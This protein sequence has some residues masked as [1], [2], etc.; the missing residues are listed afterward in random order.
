[1]EISENRTKR[2]LISLTP[3]I[4]VVFILLIFFMLAS[5]FVKWKFVDLNVGEAESMLMDTNT[6]S[7]INI[8]FDGKYTLNEKV[9]NL[10]EIVTM[11]KA[12]I[13]QKNDH[14]VLIQPIGELPLQDLMSVLEVIG[15]VAGPNMSLLKDDS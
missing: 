7:V 5:S 8:G 15:H 2:S 9:M 13:Q 6:Q 14:P 11:V 4:D 10:D 3:L 1:M 12:R